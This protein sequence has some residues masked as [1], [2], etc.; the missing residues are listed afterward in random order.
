M[1]SMVTT[2]ALRDHELTPML[3][4]C[5]MRLISEIPLQSTAG[6]YISDIRRWEHIDNFVYF[7]LKCS[8]YLSLPALPS[9][10]KIDAMGTAAVG[11]LAFCSWNFNTYRS[12]YA[13]YAAKNTYQVL[14]PP[15]ALCC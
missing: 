8:S 10:H 13:A 15:D 5:C 1:P 4:S 2:Y 3:F 7:S 12:V 11:T 14:K 6:L 9:T